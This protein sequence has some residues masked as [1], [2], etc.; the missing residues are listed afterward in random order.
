MTVKISHLV[1][2]GFPQALVESW[3]RRLGGDALLPLQQEAVARTDLLRGESLLLVAATSAGKTFVAEMAAAS[4]LNRGRRVVYLVPTK[5]LAE[6][7]FLAFRRAFAPL[8]WR[9]FCAIHERPETDP[10]VLRGAYDLVVAVYEK[11][12]AW[13]VQHPEFLHNV[14]A[15]VVD[16]IQNLGGGARGATLEFILAKLAAAPYR[17][18]IIGLSAVLGRPD[19]VAAAIGCRPWVFQGRP[20]ELRE[21]VFDLSDNTFYYTSSETGRRGQERLVDDG[22]RLPDGDHEWHRDALLELTALLA[23]GRGEQAMLFVPSQPISRRWARLLAETAP[24]APAEATIAAVKAADPSQSRDHL[25]ECLRAGVAFHNAGLPIALREAIET[26]YNTGE[27]RVLVSTSTLAQGVNLMSRNVLQVPAMVDE[28]EWSSRTVFVPLSRQAFRNQGGRAGRLGHVA[29]FGRSLLVAAGPEERERLW[30]EYI[31]SPLEPVAPMLAGAGRL[32]KFILDLVA[33]GLVT[34]PER[35][36]A[37]FLDAYSGRMVWREKTDELAGQ[38][39]EG[40]GRL[41]LADLITRPR[42]PAWDEREP[43]PPSPAYAVRSGRHEPLAPDTEFTAT[44]LGETAAAA[45]ILPETAQLF[46]RWFQ[47]FIPQAGASAP[48]VGESSLTAPPAHAGRSDEAARS[49]GGGQAVPSTLEIL[50]LLALTPDARDAT[51]PLHFTERQR[52]RYWVELKNR[53]YDLLDDRPIAMLRVFLD[54]PGG[55]TEADDTI[56]KKALILDAWISP[57][58]TIVVENRFETLAGTIHALSTHFL[59]LAQALARI[60]EALAAPSPLIRR[61]DGLAERLYCGVPEEGIAWSRLRLPSLHRHHILALVRNGWEK[62]ADLYNVNVDDLSPIVGPACAA[63]LLEAVFP[64]GPDQEREA[65]RDARPAGPPAEG[66]DKAPPEVDDSAESPPTGRADTR[67]G[68][69]GARGEAHPDEPLPLISDLADVSLALD[70]EHPGEAVVCGRRV[71]LP[72]LAFRLLWALGREPQQ[73]V[74]YERLM[75]FVWEG[76]VVEQQQFSHHVRVIRRVLSTILAPPVAR[77]LITPQPGLGL[78]LHLAPEQVR[79]AGVDR[80]Y[81]SG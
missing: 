73:V 67:T 58:P 80:D 72:R 9:V 6:E 52:A 17:P 11:L 76:A 35:L 21:G 20:V 50:Y 12:K 30:R 47:E 65:S 70:P 69:Q 16:E 29:G 54:K 42:L 61:I 8:G 31:E 33:T 46:G 24:M 37:F 1:A 3:R 81:R 55:R 40:L 60:G 15:V 59:W 43:T 23:R 78:V 64:T 28:D 51:V 74:R 39:T 75:E 36:K 77:R 34:T 2:Q 49:G 41:E 63:A 38:I 44:G 7:K 19:D 32:D 68:G 18:Q 57:T 10:P 71:Y 48:P 79:V 45:G 53:L 5:A 13:L 22:R 62:P 14:G 25:I 4:H 26:G 27:I 56:A 66:D